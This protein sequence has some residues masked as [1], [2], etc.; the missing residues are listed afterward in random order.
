[1]T[2]EVSV[3]TSSN[4]SKVIVP[5]M[6][7]RDAFNIAAMAEGFFVWGQKKIKGSVVISEHGSLVLMNGDSL[8]VSYEG[9]PANSVT[10]IY[11][12][13]SPLRTNL[14]NGIEEVVV[15]GTKEL[16]IS[17]KTDLYFPITDAD[18]NGIDK[19]QI[20]YADK[21][22]TIEEEELKFINDTVNDISCVVE[23]DANGADLN[24]SI[25]PVK[26]GYDRVLRLE[27][28]A[29]YSVIITPKTKNPISIYTQTVKGV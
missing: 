20:Q 1:M 15:T 4:G 27:I 25:Y 21:T 17:D 3:T 28:S 26:Y 9:F 7:L 13:D 23:N 24:N 6:S 2:I 5:K 8:S 29:A 19:I 18:G 12:L 16:N 22:V 14:Y 11:A 10:D